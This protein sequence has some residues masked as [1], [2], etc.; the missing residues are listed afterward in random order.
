MITTLVC[1]WQTGLY[2]H[3]LQQEEIIQY[4]LRVLKMFHEF[5]EILKCRLNYVYKRKH[6]VGPIN[7]CPQVIRVIWVSRT[8]HRLIRKTGIFTMQVSKKPPPTHSSCNR[9]HPGCNFLTHP[10]FILFCPLYGSTEW[11]GF[12]CLYKPCHPLSMAAGESD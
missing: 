8:F 6:L 1:L 12:H 5:K 7:K 10:F 4:S 3:G 2:C 11:Q 9:D